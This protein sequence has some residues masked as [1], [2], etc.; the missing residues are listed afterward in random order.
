MRVDVVLVA[1]KPFDPVAPD[2]AQLH[3]FVII[4][5]VTRGVNILGHPRTRVPYH[6]LDAV[7]ELLAGEFEAVAPPH[8]EFPAVGLQRGVVPLGGRRSIH[9]GEAHADGIHVGRIA[10]VPVEP[11]RQA[12][13]EEIEVGTDVVGRRGL[14]RQRKGDGA[15]GDGIS[16]Q[17]IADDHRRRLERHVVDVFVGIDIPVAHGTGGKTDLEVVQPAVR[18]G[19]ELFLPAHR[20]R[21]EETPL[22]ILG[23]LR[24]PVV[25]TAELGKVPALVAIVRAEEST[26]IAPVVTP[27]RRV[28]RH[29][30]HQAETRFRRH[31]KPFAP[32]GQRTV[33]FLLEVPAAQQLERMVV[34]KLGGIFG[35]DVARN[36][37][38]VVT[39]VFERAAL[40][41]VDRDGGLGAGIARIHVGHPLAR[42]A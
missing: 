5:E 13:L 33:L 20:G 35:V 4:V 16:T 19:H 25:T 15:R 22:R 34:A 36:V 10:A 21:G 3:A 1:E 24:R 38:H 11:H 42:V 30:V 18:P 2:F 32:D 26:D 41:F 37:V 39:D 31:G 12:V 23:E 9:R 40:A 29:A 17:R 8:R 28:A 14:P 6:G 7:T 27:D